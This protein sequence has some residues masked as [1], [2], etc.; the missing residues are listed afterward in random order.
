MRKNISLLCVA[1]GCLAA[2]TSCNKNNFIIFTDA[3]VAF[4]PDKSSSTIIDC[5]GTFTATYYVHLTSPKPSEAI[6]V[7]F[8]VTPGSGLKEGVDY[9]VVTTGRLRFLP[10]IYDNQVKIEWLSHPI[11]KSEDNTLTISLDSC[12]NPDVCLGVIGPDQKN[13]TIVI[14]KY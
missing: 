12:T 5:E 3:F 2:L 11:D 7:D 10:G 1:I 6:Y 8:S 9:N 4:Q 13:R 14:S